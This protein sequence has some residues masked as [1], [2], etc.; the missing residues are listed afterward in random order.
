MHLILNSNRKHNIHLGEYHEICSQHIFSY[1]F[2]SNKIYFD[3]LL[4]ETY[5]VHPL[6]IH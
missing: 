1:S 2:K 3:S 4:S 6:K 5:L